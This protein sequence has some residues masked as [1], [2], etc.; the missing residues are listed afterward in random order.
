MKPG[1]HPVVTR[2]QLD[3]LST[4]FGVLRERMAL[5]T[6]LVGSKES[7]CARLLRRVLVS[8]DTVSRED[9]LAVSAWEP[10]LAPVFMNLYLGLSTGL[11]EQA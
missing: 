2:G 10:M 7:A 11:V 9:F 5:A 3:G 1:E 8:A 6:R 4:K